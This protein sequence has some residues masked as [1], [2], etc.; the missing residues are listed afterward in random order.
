MSNDHYIMYIVCIKGVYVE[1]WV[2]GTNRLYTKDLYVLCM[3]IYRYTN[4]VILA[5]PIVIILC[6]TFFLET[7]HK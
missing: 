1:H 6:C 7:N 2:T 4:Q 3:Y 5:F